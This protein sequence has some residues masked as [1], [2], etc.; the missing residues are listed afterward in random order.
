M[1]LNLI[2]GKSNSGKTEYVMNKI[3]ACEESM[4]QAILFVPSSGRIIAEE[5]YMNYTNKNAII[6]T[7]ITSFERFVNRR[8]NKTELYEEKNYLKDMTKKMLVKKIV[9]QNAD[10]FKV[11]SKVKD[12]SGFVNKLAD[13]IDKLDTL[14]DL[15]IL[16][17]YK[18][19]DFLK[20]KLEEFKNI[21]LKLKEDLK[22][23][24]VEATDE[25]K[26]YITML[27]R[28]DTNLVNAEIFIDGYNNFSEIE[29]T[30]IQALLQ[31][32]SKVTIT[33]DIDK[34]KHINGVTEIYGSSFETFNKLK[35]ICAVNGINIEIINLKNTKINTPEDIRFVG[36]NIFNMTKVE[37]EKKVQNVDLILRPNIYEEIKYIAEDISRKHNQQYEYKDMAIYTNNVNVYRTFIKKIFETYNIPIYLNEEENIMGNRIIIYTKT[38]LDIVLSGFGKSIDNVLILLKTQLLD[39]EEQDIYM[40]E[41]YL[42]EFGIR[43]YLL[44]DRFTF[45]SNYDLEKL[46]LIREKIINIVANLK[47][48]ITK[49]KTS[50]EIT[51]AIYAHLIKENIISRYQ[52]QLKQIKDIDINEYNKNRQAVAK[53]YEILD[54]ICLVYSNE[55][56]TLKEYIELF[57]YG[58]KETM[59]DTIPAKF[60]EVEIIDINKARGMHKRIIYIIGCYDGGLPA[61]QIEDNIFTDIE[62]EKLKAVGIELK[63]TSEQRHNMQLFNIYQAINK[64][65]EKLIITVPASL[66]TGATLRPSSLINEIKMLLN[67][68]LESINYN[69]TINIDEAFIKFMSSLRKVDEISSEEEINKLY[70]MYLIYKDNPKYKEI[71][72]YERMDKS[73]EM[74]TLN[75]IYDKNINSSVSRLEQ[76]KRC[77]FA[78]YTKYILNIKERKQY[79]MSNLDTGSFMHEAIEK[80]SKYIVAKN[81][82]WQDI[83]LDEKIKEKAN[84]QINDIVEK[85]FEQE[86]SK[87]LTSSRY[88][89]LKNKMKKAVKRTIF[90]IAESFNHSEF[91]PLGYEIEFEKDSLYAPIEVKLDSGTTLLLRGKIDRI[92]SLSIGDNTYLR[93]VDYK[94]SEK[95]LKLSD[96]KTGISLQ[97][98]TYMCAMLENKE[99]LAAKN[100]VPAALSYFTISNKILSIPSYESDEQKITEKIRKALKLRGI[101]IK[102]LEILKKLDNNVEDSKESYL[103]VSKITIN[104]EEKVLP[105]E[106][107]VQECKNIRDILKDIAKEIVAGNVKIQPNKSI[108]GVCEYCSYASVCRKN[109]LN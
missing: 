92:D 67:I 89:V 18:E 16:D 108:T 88:I 109:L 11:F 91:R 24:F 85:L 57:E 102:D 17:K 73:L 10:M 41:N 81:I 51:E 71:L 96:V 69:E 59:V 9:T 52:E 104:N 30:F 61:I 19:Q 79:V 5:E 93:I 99:K 84:N 44:Q 103:E 6:D 94:S 70:N 35:E 62:L 4:K 37:L 77:P 97:L 20:T 90:A 49:S 66:N 48:E 29:Y 25:M 39:I 13:Y 76:F 8:V 27:N 80:F 107:F 46:N 75:S 32:G 55:K 42:L 14:E 98:M 22:D 7:V 2:L 87:Y 40:F 34:E 33:L 54:N 26:E 100:V 58:L 56:I 68:Q 1:S 12:S 64:A 86:Y 3:M 82:S 65:R 72:N 45:N 74:E 36:E 38:L 78:Y 15:K 47:K 106:I 21:Y 28:S 60:D 63:Q 50:K 95:N 105:E 101:Y 23:R 43:G 31:N 83:I 53:M